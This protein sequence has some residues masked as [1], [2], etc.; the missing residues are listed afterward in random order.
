M[1]AITG[2]ACVDTPI[3]Y[4]LQFKAPQHRKKCSTFLNPR[5]HSN[6]LKSNGENP[7]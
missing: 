3:F 1:F 6:E 7:S 5:L 4:H 2:T